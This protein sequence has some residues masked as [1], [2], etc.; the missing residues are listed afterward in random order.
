MQEKIKKIVKCSLVTKVYVY[1]C[2]SKRP[3]GSHVE[4]KQ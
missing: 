2:L 4:Q 3:Y 1:L